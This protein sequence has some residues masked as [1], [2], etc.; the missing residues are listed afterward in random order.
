MQNLANG[1][2]RLFRR[3]NRLSRTAGGMQL[4][5][6]ESLPALA[7]ILA[8]GFTSVAPATAQNCSPVKAA[9]SV[10]I[11]DQEKFIAF[12]NE[13]YPSQPEASWLHQIQEKILAELRNNSPDIDFFLAAPGSG[14]EGDYRMK[15]ELTLMGAGQEIQIGRVRLSEVTGF[16]IT[17]TLKQNSACGFPG[18]LVANEFNGAH[19]PEAIMRDIFRLIEY[20]IDAYGSI[21]DRIQEFEK[22]HPVPPR[23]P[24]IEFSLSRD[25]VSPLKDE[26]EVEIRIQ[27][28]NCR[29]EPVCDRF[30]GQIVMLPRKT[31]RGELKP[32]P[33]FPQEA[34][35]QG[36][37]ILLKLVRPQGGSVTYTLKKGVDLSVDTFKMETCGMDR[38]AIEEVVV[39]IAGL[40]LESRAQAPVLPADS[41]TKVDLKL[42]KM[43]PSGSREPLAGRKISLKVKGLK[44]AAGDT[45]AVVLRYG[46]F[47]QTVVDFLIIAFAIFMVVKAINAMQKKQEEAPPAPPKPSAQEV[48]LTEIRDLL[49]QGR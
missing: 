25:Y 16:A 24:E 31:E 18:R 27:V 11:V 42:T 19:T 3:G 46:N 43:L 38:K 44:A 40:A 1:L 39:P 45:P 28:K 36:D 4:H 14:V 21:S 32:T 23:G 6:P 5:F 22:S 29:G 7:C 12:L 2:V 49:K 17:S 20:N 33:R 35:V 47:I 9:V 34:E 8:L 13:K 41:S 10:N 30:R 15:F 26:R 48:L 37:L